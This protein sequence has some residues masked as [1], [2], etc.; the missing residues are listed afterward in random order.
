MGEPSCEGRVKA[1]ASW[2]TVGMS[3]LAARALKR[4][5]ADTTATIATT[6][7][8]RRNLFTRNLLKTGTR[9]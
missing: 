3:S 8:R 7:E 9:D 1:G 4:G 6:S 5:I 2:P